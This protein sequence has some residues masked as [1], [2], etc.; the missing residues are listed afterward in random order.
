VAHGKVGDFPVEQNHHLVFD[1]HDGLA[2]DGELGLVNEQLQLV[3]ALVFL[4]L[5]GCQCEAGDAKCLPNFL[6]EGVAGEAHVDH[7]GCGVAGAGQQAETLTEFK[8]PVDQHAAL[9]E[10]LHLFVGLLV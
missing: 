10:E 6:L 8:H 4:D 5:F 3:F 7:D 1:L 2:F 9:L